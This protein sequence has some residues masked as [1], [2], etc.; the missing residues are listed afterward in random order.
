[1]TEVIARSA[2]GSTVRDIQACLAKRCAVDVWPKLTSRF[3]EAVTD[4]IAAWKA[5]PLELLYPVVFFDML[6][7]KMRDGGVVLK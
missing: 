6:R 1:M 2:R 5:R 3:T 4:W 7:A